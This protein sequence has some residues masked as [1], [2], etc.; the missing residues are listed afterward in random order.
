MNHP[1]VQRVGVKISSVIIYKHVIESFPEVDSGLEKRT[2]MLELATKN[3]IGFL[4][5]PP[6]RH[7]TEPFAG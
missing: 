2:S 7:V 1:I 3:S 6:E 5:Q 4:K